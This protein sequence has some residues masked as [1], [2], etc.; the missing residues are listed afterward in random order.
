MSSRTRYDGFGMPTD[1][2][3]V[4]KHKLLTRTLLG[5]VNYARVTSALAVWFV[6]KE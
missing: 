2:L 3:E 1:H 6:L 4:N 5:L